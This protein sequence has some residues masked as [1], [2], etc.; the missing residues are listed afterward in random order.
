MLIFSI[1]AIVL[2][3]MFL[4]IKSLI[5]KMQMICN[6]VYASASVYLYAYGC[7][8]A[9]ATGHNCHFSF[10]IFSH[11]EVCHI[12]TYILHSCMESCH[13][14]ALEYQHNW[15]ASLTF[16]LLDHFTPLVLLVM[17][18]FNSTDI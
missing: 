18:L 13:S 7:L 2:M 11:Y 10:D 5:Y 9:D 4:C 8:C 16:P 1:T 6:P 15:T 12:L 14:C 3:F 17:S